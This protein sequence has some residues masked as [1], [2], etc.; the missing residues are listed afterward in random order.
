MPGTFFMKRLLVLA[1]LTAAL[2]FNAAAQ[3]NSADTVAAQAAQ[4][5]EL[6]VNGLKVLV[7]RR[8]AAATVAMGLFVRGGARNINEKNAGIE[9]LMLSSAVEAGKKYPRQTV[10]RELSRAGSGIGSATSRDYSVV[11]MA[12]TRPHFNRLWDIFTDVTINPAFVPEDIERNRQTI[13]SGLRET[14]TTPDG[15]LQAELDRR[16]YAGHPY[17]NDV[18]GTPSTIAGITPDDLIAYHKQIMQTSRLLLVFVG[19]LDPEDIKMRVAATFGKLPRGDYKEQPYQPLIFA[20]PT[21]DVVARPALPTNYVEGVFAAPSLSSPDYYPME[22]LMAILQNL[23]YQEVRV[24]R[25]LSYAPG[26]DLNKFAVNTANISVS[27]V[28]ANES[29]TVMLQQI[30]LL[31]N[32]ELNDEVVSEIAGNFLTT[33]YLQQE[34]SSAQVGEL[35]RYELI[36]GGWRNAFEFLNRIRAVRSAD[37]RA[38]ANKYMKNLRFVV[39]GNP[40]AVDKSIFTKS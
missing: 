10:R 38:V 1:V 14:E 37:L 21:V 6:D 9:S 32:N 30:N 22:V 23:V 33:Y 16:I 36:G 7:K 5:T 15:A 39:V 8:P 17:A 31:R 25:Q 3:T 20:Q 26:A 11:S 27:S 2:A 34:T 28:K 29:V 4:V 13:L 12:T 18:D 24:Q 19:D 35:A 40:A